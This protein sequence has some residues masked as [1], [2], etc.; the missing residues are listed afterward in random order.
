MLA[1]QLR[2]LVHNACYRVRYNNYGILLDRDLKRPEEAEKNY[3]PSVGTRRRSSWTRTIATRVCFN[4]LM[5][6]LILQAL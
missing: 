6:T 2:M 4:R 5:F 3:S 1:V